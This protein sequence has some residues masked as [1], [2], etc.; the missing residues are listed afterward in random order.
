MPALSVKSRRIR[1]HPGRI[2][3]RYQ[4]RRNLHL[5]N[6]PCFS[7]RSSARPAGRSPRPLGLRRS[8]ASAVRALRSGRLPIRHRSAR[9]GMQSQRVLNRQMLKRIKTA[10]TDPLLL[11]VRPP[12]MSNRILKQNLKLSVQKSNSKKSNAKYVIA[13]KSGFLKGTCCVRISVLAPTALTDYL[14]AG[15]MRRTFSVHSRLSTC[16]SVARATWSRCDP[17]KKTLQFVHLL[18]K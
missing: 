11:E 12:V 15:A 16:F 14:P 3:N 18:G 5:A 2:R 1:T 8:W 17:G 6:R 4:F 10:E 7:A 13:E 9:P